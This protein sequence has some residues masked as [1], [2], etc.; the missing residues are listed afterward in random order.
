M[1][2]TLVQPHNTCTCNCH[3]GHQHHHHQSH[4]SHPSYPFAGYPAVIGAVPPPSIAGGFHRGAHTGAEHQH[5]FTTAPTVSVNGSANVTTTFSGL[6]EPRVYPFKGGH[7]KHTHASFRRDSL[8]ELTPHPSSL[9][10][11][12]HSITHDGQHAHTNGKPIIAAPITPLTPTP[13]QSG[14]GGESQ[15]VNSW[16][17]CL[18]IPIPHGLSGAT[19]E[20]LTYTIR[21]ASLNTGSASVQTDVVLT[22]GSKSGAQGILTDYSKV[23]LYSHYGE[24][25]SAH[26]GGSYGPPMLNEALGLGLA[27]VPAFKNG[28]VGGGWS[29]YLDHQKV[30][31]NV[32]VEDGETHAHTHVNL[33]A[34]EE[35]H[36]YL[37]FHVYEYPEADALRSL[38]VDVSA[39]WNDGEA[40]RRLKEERAEERNELRMERERLVLMKRE[41]ELSIRK[42][43][44]SVK[45]ANE[46]SE[47]RTKGELEI[48]KE[49]KEKEEELLEFERKAKE[50]YRGRMSEETER[51]RKL[52]EMEKEAEALYAKRTREEEQR[53]KAFEEADAKAKAEYKRRMEEEE[54]RLKEIAEAEERAKAEHE[55]RASEEEARMKEIEEAQRKFKEEAE[56]KAKEDAERRALGEAEWKAHEEAERK[57][58]E[59]AERWAKEQAALRHQ[60]EEERKARIEAER[61]AR[62]AA[63][64]RAKEEAERKAKEEAERQA[65]EE[66]ERKAKAA[67]VVPS[68]AEAPAVADDKMQEHIATV[69]AKLGQKC[70]NGYAWEKKA[71][72]YKCSGGGHF[73][74]FKDLGMQ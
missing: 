58:R 66:A 39:T 1:A 15:G 40:L 29:H 34:Q 9:A 17:L 42:L 32:R 43:E 50:A 33:R 27:S 13:S 63:E 55:K 5:T 41:V 38:S 57:A 49:L 36:A 65:R 21:Y 60:E 62:E 26:G 23:P 46:E 51:L 30:Y 25:R 28:A 69:A 48:E 19:L 7:V 3:A 10:P 8:P 52:E 64:Q 47:R 73:I 11:T 37:F 59:D 22:R 20:S 67:R 56:R 61:K 68:V 35:C 12:T 2:A 31:P 4:L 53:L 71:H 24:G 70:K 44:E 54:E 18:P 14:P 74:S 45:R 16:A 72:G 6:E